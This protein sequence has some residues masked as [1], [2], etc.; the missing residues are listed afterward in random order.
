[1]VHRETL[2]NPIDPKR[3]AVLPCPRYLL[4]A[5]SGVENIQRLEPHVPVLH[6]YGLGD[7]PYRFLFRG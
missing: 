1:M 4:H 6:A 2:R 3:E 7:A 5:V